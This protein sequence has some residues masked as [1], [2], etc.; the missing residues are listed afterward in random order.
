MLG[1][2]VC[3]TSSEQ[4]ADEIFSAGRRF[5]KNIV[6]SP[7]EVLLLHPILETQVELVDPDIEFDPWLEKL[8]NE[9]TFSS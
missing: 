8:W 7:Q 4:A 2:A 9:I 5:V 1:H 6:Q 3:K